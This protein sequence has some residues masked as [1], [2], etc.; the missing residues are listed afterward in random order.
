VPLRK[1]EN[2]IVAQVAN[3]LPAR[4]PVQIEA[5]K[6][7]QWGKE[8]PP[9]WPD[10]AR[11]HAYRD[12][13]GQINKIKIKRTG[14][15]Y[16]NWYPVPGGWQAK[17]PHSFQPVPYVTTSINP[18]DA[19]LVD[20]QILW[21]EGEKDVD[22]LNTL[23]LPAFTF[24]GGDGLPSGI[25]SYLKG[26][27]VVILAD[28]DEPGRKHADDKA[29]LANSAGAASVKVVR[30]SELPEKSDVSDFV[31]AG[32]TSDRLIER[33]DATP[34]QHQ[35]ATKEV[36]QPASSSDGQSGLVMRCMA[37]VHPEKIEWLWPGRIA[38]G[39]QT[40]IGG[41]PGL[42]K[43][44]ITA[45]LAAAVTTGAPWPCDEGR[46]PKGSVLILSA[47]DDAADTI[48]PRLD[49]AGAD[50]GAIHLISAVAQ[51][52]GTGR[53]TFNLQADLSLLETAIKSIGNVRLVIIDP[54]SSYFG[55]NRQP[56]KRRRPRNT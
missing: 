41:E 27:R 56:Q 33:I 23:N 25:E 35:P 11:R 17:Q 53:R 22:T 51:R 36:F 14:G 7:H 29:A 12:D 30:F 16:I 21:P 42:G 6:V 18:F 13:T 45:A 48:R 32:G 3:R 39:K 52:D 49:A 26:R 38:I 9:N 28:N 24:G 15:G 8:G 10:E 47:E 40:L 20:D 34:L 37:D 4:P 1:D 43:S 5:P 50:P 46:A 55:K 44:Q 31:A 19:E 2:G 54:V